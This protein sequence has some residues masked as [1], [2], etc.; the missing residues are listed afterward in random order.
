MRFFRYS[1]ETMIIGQQL[2]LALLIVARPLLFGA[3]SFALALL[4][5]GCAFVDTLEPR[6][7]VLNR[8]FTEY[9]DM[10]TLLNIIRAS[11]NEPMNFVVMTGTTG[12]GTLTGTEGIP[13]FI[14]GPH[15][16]V[17]AA[18][19][20][21]PARNWTFGPNTLSESASNDFTVSVLDDPQSYGALMTPLDPAMMG[22]FFGRKWPMSLLLPI[23]VN[24]VRYIPA[25]SN[26]AYEFQSNEIDPKF[27]FCPSYNA[28]WQCEN[29]KWRINDPNNTP[30]LEQCRSHD[31][32]CF[33]PIM[34]L[35]SYL[36]L[37]GLVIDV[38]AGAVPGTPSAAR[39][40]YD[41]LYNNI[42]TRTFDNLLRHDFGLTEQEFLA[43]FH[44]AFGPLSRP[45]LSG[46]I[47]CDN[48]KTR[49][50]QASN[51]QTGGTTLST[52]TTPSSL[53]INGA[54]AASKS[55]AGESAN[56]QPMYQFADSTGTGIFQ[57]STRSTWGIYQ[58]LGDLVREEQSGVAPEVLGPAF[59]DDH[60]LFTVLENGTAECFTSVMYSA[61][62]YCVPKDRPNTK[63]ILSLLHELSNLYEKPNNTQQPNSGTVRVTP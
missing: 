19:P 35:F 10:S 45:K 2:Q 41:A 53:C 16:A 36:F 59:A 12:H 9:R 34:I 7:E 39:I 62:N 40:C 47:G 57:F 21:V 61:V 37:K 43:T 38:P 52:A 44:D 48:P 8:S 17:T 26:V 11:Q 31:A 60:N 25:G 55:S 1:I 3:A 51:P 27:V 42:P 18:A 13:S 23:F 29:K 63:M 4:F 46:T 24:R 6:G 58:F 56:P 22:F 15:T 30:K 5:S 54:C 33:S 49:W 50:L 14:V 28:P 20:A 32:H